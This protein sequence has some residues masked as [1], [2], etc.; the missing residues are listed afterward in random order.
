MKITENQ[1]KRLI[2]EAA[3]EAIADAGNAP[4]SGADGDSSDAIRK[5]I[6]ALEPGT[7]KDAAKVSVYRVGADEKIEKLLQSNQP[8]EAIGFI[9][10]DYL[11]GKPLDKDNIQRILSNYLYSSSKIFAGSNRQE[12]NDKIQELEKQ[13]GGKI[14]ETIAAIEEQLEFFGQAGKLSPRHR[15]FKKYLSSMT[16]GVITAMLPLFDENIVNK[17]WTQNK[18]QES[19]KKEIKNTLRLYR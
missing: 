2:R 6:I 1:L 12:L 5:E 17:F 8:L 4:A 18:L 7:F 19:I 16:G 9:M 14:K 3:A 13:F 11:L 15:N 10:R